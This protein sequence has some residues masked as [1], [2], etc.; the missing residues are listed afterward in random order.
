MWIKKKITE[1]SI[2][3]VYRFP[4]EARR[5]K[6]YT[7]EEIQKNN[8]REDEEFVVSHIDQKHDYIAA[9]R[10]WIVVPCE[11]GPL[12]LGESPNRDKMY[13]HVSNVIFNVSKSRENKLNLILD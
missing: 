1:V 6:K 9:D 11:H 4:K 2:G 5:M 10:K 8:W 12:K 7:K 3:D 13:T